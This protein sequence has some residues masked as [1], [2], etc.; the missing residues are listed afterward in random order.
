MVLAGE[1]HMRG[2]PWPTKYLSGFARVIGALPSE[3]LVRTVQLL[4]EAR[5][6]GRR[7]YVIGNGGSAATASHFVCDLVKAAHVDGYEPLRAFALSDNTP[8]VTAWANDKSYECVFAE[9]VRALADPG[10]VV[11]AISASGNSPNIIAGL[12][13]AATKGARTV[14][15]LGFDGGAA[16]QLVEIAIHVP[17]DDYGIVESAHLA[18]C[19]AITGTIRRTLWENATAATSPGPSRAEL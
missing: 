7:V 14:G 3:P 2:V 4:L 16:I 8:L 15:L 17:S 19:H 11:I 6:T 13:A 1:E 5:A 10:D 12:T 18:I 9:Q